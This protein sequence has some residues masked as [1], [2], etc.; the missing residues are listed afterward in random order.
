[1]KL[2]NANDL[3]PLI[4]CELLNFQKE[5]KQL[6]NKY[7]EIDLIIKENMQTTKNIKEI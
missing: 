3:I 6:D 1:M 4:Q 5:K 7:I 2:P